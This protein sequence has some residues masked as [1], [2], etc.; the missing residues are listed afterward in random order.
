MFRFRTLA[1][2][3]VVLLLSACLFTACGT[4]SHSGWYNVL[5]YGVKGDGVTLNTGA[6]NAVHPQGMPQAPYWTLISADQ[7]IRLKQEQF[8]NGVLSTR[9]YSALSGG[10]PE[11]DSALEASCM[12]GSL[13]AIETV[14]GEEVIQN[15]N[16]VKS[17]ESRK[18]HSDF[19]E[20]ANRQ[21]DPGLGIGSAQK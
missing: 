13:R 12:P 20:S 15:R 17:L 11:C 6:I 1:A 16:G 10:E 19:P 18:Q 21:V 5:D 3:T 8:G 9:T 2:C 7:G 4:M 14:F